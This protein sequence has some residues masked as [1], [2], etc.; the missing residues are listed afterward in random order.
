MKRHILKDRPQRT[1]QMIHYAIFEAHSGN[2]GCAETS[3]CH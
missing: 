1:I 2:I 3:R